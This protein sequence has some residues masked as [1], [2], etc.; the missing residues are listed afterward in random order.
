MNLCMLRFLKQTVWLAMLALLAL[1][2]ESARGFALGGLVGNG[3]DAYQT[4][5]LAY[6]LPGDISAPKEIGQGFRRVAPVMYYAA[7]ANFW[8][9]F[10]SQG[11]DALDNAVAIL[12][13]ITNVSLYN[14][15]L[16]EF[17]TETELINA[18]AAALSL[19]DLKSVALGAMT[20]QLGLFQPVR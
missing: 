13:N 9:F 12:N 20:E 8:G 1:S 11:M 18:R 5:V 17:P 15:N 10:G 4:T 16:S 14:S 2:N 6:G 3:P 7:D 19:T